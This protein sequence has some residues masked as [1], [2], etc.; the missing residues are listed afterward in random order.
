MVRIWNVFS[1]YCFSLICAISPWWYLLSKCSDKLC[2]VFGSFL[3]FFLEISVLLASFFVVWRRYGLSVEVLNP[4]HLIVQVYFNIITWSQH[5]CQN[6]EL[7]LYFSCILVPFETKWNYILESLLLHMQVFTRHTGG[8]YTIII[9]Q[10]YI[11]KYH[12]IQTCVRTFS[13]YFSPF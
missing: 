3:F 9:S 13:L 5:D 12:A 7:T 6:V 8:Q 2:T 10:S 1:L 4:A 11:L